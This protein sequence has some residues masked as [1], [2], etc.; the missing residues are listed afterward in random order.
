MPDRAQTPFELS[1]ARVAELHARAGGDAW[2]VSPQ[3]FAR[4]LSRSCAHR[5]G[6]TG[7][8]AADA[9]DTY[10]DSLHLTDL[11]LACACRD[12]NPGAWDHFMREIQPTVHT[13]AR[14]IAGETGR[15]LA[16]ALIADLY[17]TNTRDDERRSLL[18]YFHGRSRLT[19]WLRAVVAQRHVDSLRGNRRVISFDAIDSDGNAPAMGA[20]GTKQWAGANRD[21][22]AEDEVASAADRPRVLALF[23]RQL[24]AAVAALPAADRL[25]LSFYYVHGLTLARIGRLMHEHESSVSRKLERTRR[26]LREAVERTLRDDDGLSDADLRQCYEETS[27][28][29]TLDA[30]SLLDTD[31]VVRSDPAGIAGPARAAMTATVRAEGRGAGHASE[32]SAESRVAQD[33]E[34]DSFKG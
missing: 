18:D 27:R 22:R 30:A 31:Q 33:L 8:P 34:P 20:R 4:A 7:A 16:D 23:E 15:D 28:H 1:A 24:Q 25:R 29:G 12:G 26:E 21:E 19:T 17:G 3:R 11:A 13:A 14:A 5:F 32:N 9:L 6:A 10:L 2:M